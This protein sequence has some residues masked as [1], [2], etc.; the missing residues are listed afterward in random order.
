MNSEA[1]KKAA[2]LIHEADSLFI[3]TG[4]GMGVDSGLADFRG[5]HGFWKAYPKL[6]NAGIE[7]T[8]M[9]NPMAFVK[10][11]RQAWG[12]YGHRL[13]QYRQTKPHAGFDILKKLGESRPLGYFV[14]TSNVDGQ[15]QK[16]G[17]DP[18][19]IAECHGSIHHLQCQDS[20]TG[21]IWE[22]DDLQVEV[23]T[24]NCLLTS[25]LPVCP[26]CRSLARP[27]ILM[28]NDW[29]W[30]G[31]RTEWQIA[32]LN[33]WYHRTKKMA[34]IELGAGIHVPTVRR[35]CE[36]F[37]VP[38]IRINPGEPQVRSNN[39]VSLPLGALEALEKI[40]SEFQ[41]LNNRS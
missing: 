10:N 6:G 5:N 38:M 40:Y 9:A 31:E 11:P 35:V 12:F 22:A 13:N 39:D 37:N 23:D 20:C 30:I 14:F 25:E 16:A 4:A 41:T 34:V 3:G 32:K 19:I 8:E 21:A 29:G 1:I 18:A 28:F 17:F 24:E 27:N 26:E 36:S 33:Q 15:F 2:Q 7:F